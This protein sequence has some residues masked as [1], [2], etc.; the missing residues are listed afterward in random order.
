MSSPYARC[1]APALVFL[2]AACAAGPAERRVSTADRNLITAEEMRA[3]GYTDAFRA[4]QSLRPQWLQI[5][6]PTSFSRPEVIKVYLDG[7]LM[8]G[9]EQLRQIATS[10]I[11]S[12]RFLDANEATQRWGLDHGNGAILVSTRGDGSRRSGTR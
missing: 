5:R 1:L 8:G 9:P 3:A 11:S 6:G 2:L 10:S 12:I 7:S 4:V